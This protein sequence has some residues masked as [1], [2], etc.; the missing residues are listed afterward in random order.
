MPRQLSKVQ[1][2]KVTALLADGTPHVDVARL[3]GCSV[4]QVRKMSSNLL[5]FGNVVADIV[6]VQGRPRVIT[7]AMMEV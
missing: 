7:Q 3:V 5:H 2:D 1:R 6:P 4:G